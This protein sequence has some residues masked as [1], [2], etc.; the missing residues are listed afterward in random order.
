M[1]K[2]KIYKNSDCEKCLL[3]FETPLLV[4]FQ[5]SKGK[6]IIICTE[7]YQALQ[8]SLR[9]NKKDRYGNKNT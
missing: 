5:K 8:K 4:K 2:P 3:D 9:N 7:C 1:E 6:H